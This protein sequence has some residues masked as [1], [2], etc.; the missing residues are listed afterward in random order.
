MVPQL[1]FSVRKVVPLL[2][3][4]V[5]KVVPLFWFSVFKVVSLLWFSV[6]KVV[7]LLWFSVCLLLQMYHCVL[8]LFFISSFTASRRLLHDCGLPRVLSYEPV[9]D[10]TYSKTM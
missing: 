4:S 2:L 6:F 10:K 8:S 1:R 5:C 3:F 9:H 7:P